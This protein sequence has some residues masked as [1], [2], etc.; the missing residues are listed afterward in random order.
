MIK[1]LKYLY[2]IISYIIYLFS[3]ICPR[4]KNIWVFGCYRN[5]FLD[6]SKYLFI[7]VNKFI[8]NIRA[9]WITGSD[10]TLEKVRRLGFEVYKRNSFWGWFYCMIARIYIYSSYISD[11]NF[12]TSGGADCVNLWHGVGLK[13]IEFAI[14][15]GPLFEIYHKNRLINMFKY[16]YLFKRPDILLSSS[17]M[18]SIQ[19][20]NAFRIK[21]D[22]IIEYGYPRN[23]ILLFSSSNSKVYINKYCKDTIKYINMTPNYNQTFLWVPTWR[24]D[25]VNIFNTKQIDLDLINN[26]LIANNYLLFIKLHVNDNINI[27]NHYSNIINIPNDIDIYPLL[28][29]IN[30]L[31]TDYSSIYYDA[32]LL[33]EIKY[34]FFIYDYEKYISNRDFN[35]D[36]FKYT[37]G[38]YIS[39]IK[40]FYNIFNPRFNYSYGDTNSLKVKIWGDNY[41]NSCEKIVKHLLYQI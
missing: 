30:I 24:D 39:E 7:Y 15:S 16:P 3:F 6:N 34:V 28:R 17:P 29:H 2:L 8:N 5:L 20:A 21:S 12:F 25:H 22:R 33:D 13:K 37:V 35:Y 36:Y 18:Q 31:I 1:I 40:D 19:F 38:V 10:D 11:I 27:D 26:L 4:S 9:I 41:M 32:L 23:E 14:E